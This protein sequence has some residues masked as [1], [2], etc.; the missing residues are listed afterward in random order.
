MYFLHSKSRNMLETTGLR[1]NFILFQGKNPEERLNIQTNYSSN[2][3]IAFKI[4]F[5]VL[6]AT[7]YF[8]IQKSLCTK[9][10]MV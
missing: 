6:N 7:G 10:E 4:C 3:N 9:I 5:D 1:E 2:K 8:V